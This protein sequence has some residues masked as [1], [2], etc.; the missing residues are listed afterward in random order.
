MFFEEQTRIIVQ[1]IIFQA[2]SPIFVER[3]LLK[4]KLLHMMIHVRKISS[5]VMYRCQ[6]V[7]QKNFEHGSIK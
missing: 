3:Y 4:K 1:I 7:L 5:T 6:S 2:L